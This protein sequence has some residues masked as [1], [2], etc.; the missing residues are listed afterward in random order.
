MTSSPAPNTLRFVIITFRFQNNTN[1]LNFNSDRENISQEWRKHGRLMSFDAGI[2]GIA[3]ANRL[4]EQP[5]ESSSDLAVAFPALSH[6]T[7]LAELISVERGREI[8]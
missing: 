4:F 7:S 1:R 3:P 8:S 5:C 6:S 2:T